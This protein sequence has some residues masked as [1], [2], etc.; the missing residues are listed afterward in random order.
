MSAEALSNPVATIYAA[1]KEAM[2]AV[3]GSGH[4][5]AD[6]SST[7]AS[8]PYARIFLMQNPT[9]DTDL[10]GNECATTI[11]FQTEIFTSGM[12]A[13]DKAYE[14]DAVSHATMIGLGFRRTYGAS[15]IEN[16]DS[17]VKRLVSRYSMLFTG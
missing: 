7:A 11:S 5:S 16:A 8:T 4:V 2:V 1:W 12:M 17:N 13:L 3:V 9:E 14:Y 15:I 6:M 10:E